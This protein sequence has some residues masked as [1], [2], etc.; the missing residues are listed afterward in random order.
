MSLSEFSLVSLECPWC[1]GPL[2][3]DEDEYRFRCDKGHYNVICLNG[4]IIEYFDKGDFF[5]STNGGERNGILHSPIHMI[6]NRYDERTIMLPME[7]RSV[8][9]I[10][11]IINKYH[12]NPNTWNKELYYFPNTPKHCPMCGGMVYNE[13]QDLPDEVVC[14]THYSFSKGDEDS[15]ESFEDEDLTY[16]IFY[17]RDIF[18]F[19]CRISIG[20]NST[21]KVLWS[22]DLLVKPTIKEI[23]SDLKR[24]KKSK[25]MS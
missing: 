19:E 1:G 6:N 2:V 23:L 8:K 10:K 12:K 21:F 17:T 15:L 7:E 13:D 18:E 11:S 25:I 16:T 5:L 4:E 22:D 14:G 3:K 24:Y 9:K 20:V